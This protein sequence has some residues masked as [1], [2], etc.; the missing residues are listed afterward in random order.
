MA[1]AT[2]AAFGPT[3]LELINEGVDVMAVDA[4]LA[5]STTTAKGSLPDIR[6]AS[7]RWVSPS[8]I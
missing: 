6:I 4:D 3:L 2:R 7:S 8:R 1:K 5:G